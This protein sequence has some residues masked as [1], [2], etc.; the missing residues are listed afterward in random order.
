MGV[1]PKWIVTVGAVVGGIIAI[2]AL[3]SFASYSPLIRSDF[4]AVEGTVRSAHEMPSTKDTFFEIHLEEHSV[5]FRIPVE[6][7][8]PPFKKAEFRSNVHPGSLIVLEVRKAQLQDPVIPRNDPKPTVFVEGV[9]DA[10]MV[11]Y[12]LDD[13][14]KWLE[15]NR[16]SA[17]Y[18]GL[19]FVFGTV[20][21]LIARKSRIV[22]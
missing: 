16:R 15:S 7:Y 22:S 13:R 14:R 10:T 12:D 21:L 1:I 2:F 8:K 5:R 18:L 17:L 11:Y 19:F 3:Y 20:C 4:T 6:V 9:R